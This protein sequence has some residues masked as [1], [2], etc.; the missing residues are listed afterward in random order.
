MGE[1][2]REKRG[3]IWRF[4]RKCLSLHNSYN[5]TRKEKQDDNSEKQDDNSGVESFY[6][7]DDSAQSVIKNEFVDKCYEAYKYHEKNNSLN[8]F[9]KD[10]KVFVNRYENIAK[11]KGV[12]INFDLLGK[13]IYNKL[14]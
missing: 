9:E 11:E 4:R 13:E 7:K 1:I 3:K 2:L 14:V 6:E 5:R 8:K 12:Y 10:I